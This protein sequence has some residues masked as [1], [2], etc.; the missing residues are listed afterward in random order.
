MKYIVFFAFCLMFIIG[1]MVSLK[2]NQTELNC[3][4]DIAEF[5]QEI[6]DVFQADSVN[7]YLKTLREEIYFPEINSPVIVIWNATTNVLDFKEIPDEQTRFENYRMIEEEL[8][9]EGLPFAKEI[10]SACDMSNYNDL[11]I[12]FHEKYQEGKVGH[13]FIC[14]YKELLDE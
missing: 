6:K 3:S 13:R 14:H 5:E 2:N 10:I 9:K 7:I 8:K 4:R 1:C 11:I 12:E